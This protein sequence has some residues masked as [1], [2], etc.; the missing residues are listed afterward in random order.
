VGCIGDV[1]GCIGDVLGCIRDIL[2]RIQD[3]S[4]CIGTYW[5]SNLLVKVNKIIQIRHVAYRIRT[6]T[7]TD[8]HSYQTRIRYLFGE[9][10]KYPSNMAW[11]NE[12]KVLRANVL[13]SHLW[14]AFE[15]MKWNEWTFINSLDP[16]SYIWQQSNS[17]INS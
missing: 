4:K 6:R 15:Y 14:A 17:F 2:R 9:L 16:F 10:E 8:T 3:V 11:N 7:V 13:L 5:R 1:P 12:A